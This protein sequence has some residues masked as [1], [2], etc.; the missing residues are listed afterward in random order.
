MTT[1]SGKHVV[2]SDTPW[3]LESTGPATLREIMQRVEDQVASG[4]IEHLR[5]VATGFRPL[6]DVLSGGLRP[7]ELMIVGGRQGVGKTIFALQ[8]ARNAVYNDEEV[9]ALYV[10]YEHDRP[11]LLS[12]L[13]CLES[14]EQGCRFPL[15]LKTLDKMAL[16]SDDGR[17]LFTRLRDTPG[18]GPV[19]EAAE[20]YAERLVLVKASGDHS[21]LATI[22]E[23][24]DEVAS[25]GEHRLLLVVD[26]LQKVPVDTAMLQPETEVTTH[27]TQ[28]L[29]N[30]AM[31]KGVRVIAIAAADRPGLKQN[32]VRFS[33]LR[34][35][36]ALQYEA[37]VGLMLN[38]KHNVLSRR[39]LIANLTEA[40]KTRG[41][42]V[43]SVEKNRAGKNIVDMEHL[44]Q[45]AQ[46]RLSP[47]GDFVRERLVDGKTILE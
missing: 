31:E 9:E 18:Y 4:D 19:V 41:W 22:R 24:V 35:S 39:Q 23:W 44:L 37:D 7:G 8:V 34:G 15:T 33:D 32:R 16:S 2:Q 36:S 29:K 28:G 27:L 25:P 5:P 42:V 43:L 46:F 30:L 11:H 26:Y 12:R 45:A 38:N 10:C 47:S 14:V 21:T 1:A 3:R 13:L 20:G 40:E 6:D 17:G